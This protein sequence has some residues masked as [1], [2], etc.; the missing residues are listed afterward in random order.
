MHVL[1]EVFLGADAA[2]RLDGSRGFL[3]GEKRHQQVDV[4]GLEP[5]PDG[6]G[7]R[8]SL[9]ALV[10]R[11][12][13]RSEIHGWRIVGVAV[14]AADLDGD[15][16]ALLQGLVAGDVVIAIADAREAE[17]PGGGAEERRR[18]RILIHRGDC[19]AELRSP[20]PRGV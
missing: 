7:R 1:P 9:S 3:Y 17:H 8:Q 20:R 12:L 2:A 10:E 14:E 6:S 15:A 18:I 13:D 4:V 11:R 16:E 19:L 5:A